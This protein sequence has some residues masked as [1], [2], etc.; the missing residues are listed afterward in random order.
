LQVSLHLCIQVAVLIVSKSFSSENAFRSH[1]QSKKHREREAMQATAPR[2][3]VDEDEAS[4]PAAPVPA[5]LR[6]EQSED[7]DEDGSS[8]GDIDERIAASR[9]RRNPTDCLF[10]PERAQSIPFI[11]SHMSSQHSFFV[12]DQDFLHDAAGLLAYLGE[13]VVIGNLCLYCPNG[14]KEFG[15]LEAVRKHMI[16]KAHCKIAFESEED[17]AEFADFYAYSQEDEAGSDWEDMDVGS[18]DEAEAI[19]HAAKVSCFSKSG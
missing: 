9:R 19:F 7:E 17:Q 12:P 16:D 5:I 3:D 13:K 1:V 11:L 14:G 8:E 10:C 18:G 2:R 4:T 15:S 6:D